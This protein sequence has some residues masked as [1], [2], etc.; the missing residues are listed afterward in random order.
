[1]TKQQ[2]QY[3]LC[4]SEKFPQIDHFTYF[5]CFLARIRGPTDVLEAQVEKPS[6][7]KRHRLNRLVKDY[8]AVKL[9]R[10]IY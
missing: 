10:S 3:L 9:F 7:K 5:S 4:T 6:Y 1:M 2:R 8:E